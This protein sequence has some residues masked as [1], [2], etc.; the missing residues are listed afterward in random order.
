MV[1]P[2]M[3]EPR[4]ARISTNGISLNVAEAGPVDGPLAI[5]LHGFPEFWY[6]WRHQI[7]PLAEAG[8]RVLAPD[9][10][11]Y[12]TSDKPP[13]VASY[14]LDTLADDVVGLIDACGRDRA[15]VVGH[16]WGGAVAWGSIARH[17]SRFDRAVILNAPHP[18]A[19]F[20]ELKAN[21]AQLLR[22]WYTLAFQ[23][24]WLP[25]AMLRRADFRGLVRGME[26]SSRPGTFQ[27]A[28]FERYRRAWSEP[29][30][31]TSMVHWYRA[32][33]RYRHQPYSD[34]LVKVPTLMIW[35]AKD[36]F[37]G[38]GVARSSYAL[39]ESA[40]LEWI[41]EATHWVQHEEPDRVNRLILDFLGAGRASTT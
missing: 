28:D 17:P 37:L 25:E 18:D 26:R 27:P 16:D 6:G 1:Q 9:Q 36:L 38:P 11:G 24:P 39:C 14:A 15:T 20:R 35:G 2:M 12:N 3:V 13:K 34:P 30:A 40:R 33:F 32:G 21:P 22:S 19:M 41:E 8:Y 29:G 4:F 31:L 5:L 7:G 23:V 10:R